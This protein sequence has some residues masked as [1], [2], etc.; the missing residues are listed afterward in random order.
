[1]SVLVLFSLFLRAAEQK[2]ELKQTELHVA[3][4][5]LSEKAEGVKSSYIPSST[6]YNL[7]KEP[8]SLQD[9]KR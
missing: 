7:V 3:R 1:M 4:L 8:F 6:P 5:L 2:A 9:S